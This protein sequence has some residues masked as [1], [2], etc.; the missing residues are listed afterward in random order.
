MD[1]LSRAK[2]D[3]VHKTHNITIRWI[4]GDL[5]TCETDPKLLHYHLV[6]GCVI[7]CKMTDLKK[8][9]IRNYGKA[10]HSNTMHLAGDARPIRKMQNDFVKQLPVIPTS[11]TVKSDKHHHAL[12]TICLLNPCNPGCCHC[13]VRS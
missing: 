13:Q 5:L 1:N 9:T 6:V 10:Q 2:I 3:D 12:E 11:E 7:H 4:E 8:K